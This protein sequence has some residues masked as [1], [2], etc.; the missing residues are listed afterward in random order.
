MGTVIVGMSMSLDGFVGGL[1][2][3]TWWPAHERLLGWVF[4]LASWR[5]R[6]GIEGGEHNDDSEVVREEQARTGA[7]IMGRRMFDFGEEPWGD[8]PPFRAPV[9][10]LTH[11]EREPVMKEGGTRYTFVTDGVGSAI[12]QAKAAAGD[13]D[14]FVSG[15]AGAVQA[16]LAAGLLDE[17]EVHLAPVLLGE[18]VRLFD[19][20][21]NAPIELERTRVIA[22]SGTTHIR[23]RVIR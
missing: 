11:R 10:V 19:H 18:G 23:F 20:I 6:Q 5:E 12:R 17:I 7:Y 1:S 2:E 3:A 4:D 13:K 9:F 15:G 14:V 21:G 16:V 8:D 22:S